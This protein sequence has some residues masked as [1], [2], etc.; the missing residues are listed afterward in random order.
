[1]ARPRYTRR[2]T[3]KNWNDSE[4]AARDAI[5]DSVAGLDAGAEDYFVKPFAFA[6]LLARLRV[7]L[8]RS[9]SEQETLLRAA[10]LEVDLLQRQVFHGESEMVL[11]PQYCPP[12]PTARA[13]GKARRGEAGQQGCNGSRSR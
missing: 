7:L 9:S 1:M 3:K 10:D 4:R 12:M 13:K 8:R 11:T 2:S 6:E 5:E